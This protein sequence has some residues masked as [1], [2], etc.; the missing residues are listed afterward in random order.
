MHNFFMP[1]R[2]HHANNSNQTSNKQVTCMSIHLH[3]CDFM[4]VDTT[5]FMI[6]SP[7][8]LG[9]KMHIRDNIAVIVRK[10]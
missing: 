5:A 1:E 2:D 10:M 6:E 4:S 3:H 8:G 7:L 9:D